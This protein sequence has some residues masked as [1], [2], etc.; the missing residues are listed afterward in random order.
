MSKKVT[1]KDFQLLKAIPSKGKISAT[2]I[3]I[4]LK[5]MGFELDKRTVQRDLNKLSEFFAIQTDG[6]KDVAGWSWQEN[7]NKLELPA[8][9]PDVALSFQI[10]QAH[11]VQ[12]MPPNILK[13]LSP[14]FNNANTLLSSLDSPLNTWQ[15]KIATL[16]RIQPLITPNIDAQHLAEIYN[17]LLLERKIIAT[18]KPLG[19]NQKDYEI[20]P[21]GIVVVDKLLYLVCSLWQYSDI[22]QLALHRFV[23]VK[24]TEDKIDKPAAFILQE[25][26][27]NGNFLFPKK[28]DKNIDLVMQIDQYWANYLSENKL[29]S[30]QIIEQNGDLFIINASIKSTQ[31]LKWWILSMG[32]SAL[33]IQPK[34]LRNE[35]AKNIKELNEKYKI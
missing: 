9:S 21:L 30:T 3:L 5:N 25:Y 16:S 22:K 31:Q 23:E 7:A 27:D 26:I 13:Q 19:E 20:N 35:I 33:V 6:N 28:I 12:F 1:Y 24:V 32:N 8:M 15:H 11:L 18:Y 2:Q 4:Q 14:Y 10:L 34:T 29:S 17:A